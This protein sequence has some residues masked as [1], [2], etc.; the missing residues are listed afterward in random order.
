[1]SDQP[2]PT[3]PEGPRRGRPLVERLGLAAIAIVFALL[4]GFVGLAAFSLG[5]P[6]LGVMG[7][8]GCLMT[9]WV[10]GITLV[11]G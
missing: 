3:S 10:G 5:E 7:V 4:F 2:D 9:L 11:R 1:M 8:V 6:F